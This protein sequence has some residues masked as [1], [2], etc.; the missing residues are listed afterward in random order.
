MTQVLDHGYVKLLDSMPGWKHPEIAGVPVTWGF[1]D[2][3]VVDA[4]RVSIEG[5]KVV[6]NSTDAKLLGYLLKQKHT[7]PFEHVRFTF[8]VQLPMFIARQWIRHRMGSFSEMSARYG[9]LPDVFYIPELSRMN[10][11][12]TSNKQGST[13]ELI[14]GAEGWQAMIK[15]HSADCYGKYE[16]M[17]E[18]GMARELARMVLPVNIYTKW[19][20]TVDLHNLMHFLKLRLDGHAQ[21]EIRVYGEAIM[22]LIDPIVPAT[23]AVFRKDVLGLAA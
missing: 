20:W 8:E 19:F 23:M 1:G 15:G 3:R 2:Q 7:T 5:D 11:Q 16:A 22:D 17:L 6:A 18:G 12:A 21:Y 13:S 14:E 10:K 9:A 4:A